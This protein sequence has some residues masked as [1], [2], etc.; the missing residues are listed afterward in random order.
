MFSWFRRKRRE[1]QGSPDLPLRQ[2]RD[3]RLNQEASKL[4]E[5]IR[6]EPRWEAARNSPGNKE[7]LEELR[8]R[9]PGYSDEA[10]GSA[11]S[12]GFLESR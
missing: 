10:Y 2:E 3:S 12:M 9:C 5:E 7:G 6:T 1:P 4:A 8:R 11:L